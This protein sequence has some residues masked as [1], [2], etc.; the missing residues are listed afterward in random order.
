MCQPAAGAAGAV[1]AVCLPIWQT[2]GANIALHQVP[3]EY[4]PN[5][6]LPRVNFPH[7]DPKVRTILV[8]IFYFFCGLM[9][10]VDFGRRRRTHTLTH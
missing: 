5:R 7:P 6:F 8:G 2:V 10:L 9:M 4:F 3:R 1:F